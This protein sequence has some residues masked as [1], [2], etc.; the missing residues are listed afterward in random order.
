LSVALGAAIFGLA[1]AAAIAQEQS[2]AAQAEP[3]QAAAADPVTELDSVQVKGFRQS[4]QYS[5]Q[6]KRDSTGFT[7]SIFA[8]DIGKFPDQNIAESLMRVP[9]IQ[10]QRDVNGEGMNVAIRGL[11]NSFTKTLINGG[12]VA[13]ASVGLVDGN[14]N[15]EV[16]LNL[17]PTE[18]FN[19]LTVYKTSKASLQEGGIGGVVDM[20]SVRPFDNPG[21]H[22]VYNLQFNRNEVIDETSPQG[23][24]F[25]SWTNESGTFGVMGGAS[26]IRG[27]TAATGF[28]SVGWTNPGLTWQQCGLTPP[29][30]T[31][32]TSQ[33]PA[34]NVYG[35]GNWSIPN[36]V[37]NRQAVIDAG[38]TP[39]Q[40][41]DQ[42][43][44]L[45]Q[46]PGLTIQ[47]ISEALI[48]RL[49]RP[50]HTA[51]D[52]NRDAYVASLEWRPS[53]SAHYYLDLM[54]SEKHSVNNR[55]DVNLIGRSGQMIPLDMTIDG[56]PAGSAATD[57]NWTVQTATFTNAQYFLEAR[58]FVQD[59]DYWRVNPGATWWLSDNVRID[60]QASHSRSA[61]TRSLPTFFVNSPYTTVTYDGTGA[62]PVITSDLDLNDP[63]AG[64]TIAG[65]RFNT[66]SEARDTET[67]SGRVDLQFG[68][69]ARNVRV[70]L[71]Y[72]NIS[73]Q[74][75]SSGNPNYLAHVQAT[76]TDAE[77]VQFLKPG[78]FGFI[79]FDFDAF[80]DAT[81]WH[82]Y[83]AANADTNNNTS[84]GTP[85]G[86]IDEVN[87]GAFAET[88]GE[89][90]LFGR[91]LR[92]N[93]GVRVV[94][95]E[96]Q[97]SGPVT[98]N[99]VR[100]YQTL[101]GSYR[102]VL[103]SANLAWDVADDWVVRFAASRTMT[104]PNPSSMLPATSF[105]DPSATQASQGN[106]DLKPYLSDNLDLGA[107]W[108][109]G[110]EGLVALT[111]FQKQVQ[112]YTYQGTRT[113]PFLE[114]GIPFE[115]L[116][117][118]QRDSINLRGGPAAATV[119]VTQ[120]VNA[121]AELRIRGWEA[122][123]VQPLGFL[124][125]GLGFMANYSDIELSTHGAQAAALAGNLYGISP[126][127][128]NATLYWENSAAS[129][130]VSYNHSDPFPTSGLNENGVTYA[131]R[132]F[133]EKNQ[134]DLSASYTFRSLPTQPQ[135][136][137]NIQNLTREQSRG[138]YFA[139]E[140]APY[141]YYEPGRTV[142]LGV[143]GT[144]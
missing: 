91:N 140:N 129:L 124:F 131:R 30:G 85:S 61:M 127:M 89:W 103:P 117:Q 27:K 95:T 45:A 119:N 31:S 72:D 110:D 7:D 83:A 58:P 133:F 90:D 21:T 55:I 26:I 14:G 76:I 64:W 97:I 42:A 20:R 9:G 68:D 82:E 125:D 51:G 136:T 106:P 71:A 12:E 32:A 96:Q 50:M 100:Q 62:L 116:A 29:A 33:A 142:I 77:L 126:T 128:W 80:K 38:L 59:A 84:T 143:R 53:D 10:L 115:D 2:P 44:L 3:A 60:A 66:D 94:A 67:T 132:Y 86:L 17:F 73:R 88:N 99:G 120:Q 130:R 56:G 108:Y 74:L 22:G 40:T 122:I 118:V 18:F 1:S 92:Y 6:A 39:G 63:A 113:I 43:W 98:I 102:E 78:P 87:I 101:D 36:T 138:Q 141:E 11:G 48:P 24:V 52:S 109:T 28:E 4:I 13:T 19:Q 49:A 104:R 79:T 41:I 114:L 69:D 107:E 144:W 57:Q 37:P 93:A 134:L 121:N 46:N 15:R 25:G 123:W 54:Y 34:C 111:L 8:E 139:F 105:T 5:T 75:R 70:G 65:G 23:S 135:L 35:G 16:D 47:Q 137:L 81:D 112:G